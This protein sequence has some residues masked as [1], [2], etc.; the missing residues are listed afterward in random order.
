M[1]KIDVASPE[2]LYVQ[3]R[4]NIRQ[5]ILNK[6]LLPG[7]RLPTEEEL[8]TQLSISIGT[9]KEALADLAREDL[10]IRRPRLGTFVK[11]PPKKSKEE[12]IQNIIDVIVPEI[13]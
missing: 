11:E 7:D 12:E 6:E 1:I 9:V 5:K 4:E 13:G 2:A 3:V 10:I 8:S